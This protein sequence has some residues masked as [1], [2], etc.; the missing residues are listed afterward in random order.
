[1]NA[2]AANGSDIWTG[3][4]EGALFHSRDNGGHWDALAVVDGETK[5][6]GTITGIAVQDHQ[7]IR[8]T[9]LGW[10][11]HMAETGKARGAL[12]CPRSDA[13]RG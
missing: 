11:C 4:T 13:S 3:G 2:L 12:R 6:R 10:F 8:L 7:L 1:M 9:V 5:L